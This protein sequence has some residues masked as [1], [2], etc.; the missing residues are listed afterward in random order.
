MLKFLPILVATISTYIYNISSCYDAIKAVCA[1]FRMKKSVPNLGLLFFG[2]IFVRISCI[3]MVPEAPEMSRENLC[4][5]LEENSC[6]C[7]SDVCVGSS[8]ECREER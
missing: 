1:V 6:V 7:V 8:G 3:Q 2:D 4:S 5:E